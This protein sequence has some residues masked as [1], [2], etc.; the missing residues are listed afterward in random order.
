[1]MLASCTL[2]SAA[3]RSLG[4]LH[5]HAATYEKPP[6][7]RLGP[8]KNKPPFCSGVFWYFSL[9]RADETCLTRASAPDV[10]AAPRV[11]PQGLPSAPV[12]APRRG[13]GMPTL[14]RV[15]QRR[16]SVHQPCVGGVQSVVGRGCWVSA[17]ALTW[18]HARASRRRAAAG[19]SRVVRVRRGGAGGRLGRRRQAAAVRHSVR[20]GARATAQYRR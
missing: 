16:Q 5:L 4:H 20:R 1:M 7:T 15:Q 9:H 11:R 13:G 19:R 3:R 12:G 17:P 8:G 2:R 14:L 6:A 18:R 10:G